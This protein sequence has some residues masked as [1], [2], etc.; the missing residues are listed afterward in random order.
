MS[1]GGLGPLGLEAGDDL[2]EAVD[3]LSGVLD[4]GLLACQLC[5]ESGKGVGELLYQLFVV[6]CHVVPLCCS[7]RVCA[8]R[9][10]AYI[11]T[12]EGCYGKACCMFLFYVCVGYEFI[13]W[14]YGG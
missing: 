2:L 9:A 3:G 6:A 7:L 12:Q 5:L 11:I 10:R 13:S 4:G 8:C 1:L 14:S